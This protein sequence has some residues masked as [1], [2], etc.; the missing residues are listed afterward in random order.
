MFVQLLNMYCIRRAGS[1]P[2]SC[3]GLGKCLHKLGVG[4]I[5]T[6]HLFD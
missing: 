4:S 1:A 3:V 6:L 2:R 5:T